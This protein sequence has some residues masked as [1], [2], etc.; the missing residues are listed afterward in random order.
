MPKKADVPK[1][2]APEIEQYRSGTM[3]AG[4]L[5]HDA[6]AFDE[7]LVVAEIGLE[8]RLR[9]IVANVPIVLF[10]TD[11]D[12][13]VTVSDGRGLDAM[14]LHP[15]ELNGRLAVELYANIRFI[16]DRDESLTSAVVL[17]RAL[18]GQEV[19]GLA[20]VGDVVFDTRVMPLYGGHDG[21]TI[22]GTIGVGTVVTERVR[23]EEALREHELRLAA[24]LDSIGQAVIA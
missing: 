23:A 1:H 19:H 9:T 21:K 22:T 6:H 18:A 12:G 24:T 20:Y 2:T 3:P 8:K 17:E 5:R 10:S 7:A 13:L 16:S 4:R 15:G 11:R 14:G